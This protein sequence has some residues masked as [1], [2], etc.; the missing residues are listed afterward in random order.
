MSGCPVLRGFQNLEGFFL[1]LRVMLQSGYFSFVLPPF[2]K[3][4]TLCGWLALY[5]LRLPSVR[6]LCCRSGYKDF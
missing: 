5:F 2:C 6:I 3:Q 1:N 4:A